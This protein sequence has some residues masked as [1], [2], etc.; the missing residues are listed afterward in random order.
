MEGGWEKGGGS[1]EES[2][3]EEREMRLHKRGVGRKRI[4]KERGE[5]R[6][7]KRRVGRGRRGRGVESVYDTLR[8]PRRSFSQDALMI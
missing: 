4:G 7:H 5:M 1:W 3:E 8:H 2:G 6:L